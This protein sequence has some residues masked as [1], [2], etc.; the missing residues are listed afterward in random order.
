MKLIKLSLAVAIVS[1]LAFGAEEK[2]E[3]S[4]SGSLA[5]ASNYI[6]RG[7]TQTNNSPAVQGAINL[8]Y[9]GFYLGTAGSN[10]KFEGVDTSA[11]FDALGGYTG[12]AYGIGYDIGAIEY[13]YPNAS[14]EANF[15]DIYLG[16]SKDF[17]VVKIGA[18]FYRGV[19]TNELE[20]TNAW[21]ASLLVPLPM[22]ISFDTL[23]GD[24]TD[25]GNYYSVGFTEPINDKFKVALFYTGINKDVG[26]VDEDNIVAMVS[27]SF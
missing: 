8:G 3:L 11:E 1:T 21:E 14:K 18:K 15:A 26:G 6:W 5:F 4:V 20:V 13:M 12:E 27:A 9:K 7:M 10:V 23:Y 22:G 24:Y 17:E 25:V 2:P 16:L 19:K